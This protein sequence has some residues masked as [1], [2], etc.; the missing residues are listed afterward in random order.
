MNRDLDGKLLSRASPHFAHRADKFLAQRRDPVPVSCCWNGAVVVRAEA[1]YEQ[2]ET[3]GVREI[4]DEHQHQHQH[5][6]EHQQEQQQKGQGGEDDKGEEE[7]GGGSSSSSSSSSF[8]LAAPSSSSAIRFRRPR[9]SQGIGLRVAGAGDD[10]GSCDESECTTFCRDLWRRGVR[11]TTKS[12]QLL[13]HDPLRCFVG[14][15]M[16]VI[17]LD[18][19][20]TFTAPIAHV[21]SRELSNIF[22][23]TNQARP[24]LRQPRGLVGLRLRV[25]RLEVVRAGSELVR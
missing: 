11:S 16:R 1:F 19:M 10:E 7:E 18:R 24:H 21:S 2:K 25:L 13:H 3:G 6:Q 23:S 15:A 14:S 22:R 4:D 12:V 20:V 9:A 17:Y 8:S 5:Q